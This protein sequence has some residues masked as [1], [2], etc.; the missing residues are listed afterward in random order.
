MNERYRSIYQL[1]RLNAG[2]TQ[3]VAAQLIGVAPRTLAGYEA[4][5]PIPH[6]DVVESMVDVY[7]AEWLA[8]EH[9]RISTSVGR[10]FLPKIDFTDIAKSVLVLQK[11]SNDVEQIKNTMVQIACDGNIDKHERERWLEVSK[12]VMEL[13]GA[14]LSVVFS[15]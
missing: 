15:R 14:A 4:E 10:R 3:D 11:E 6:G 13:A 12:E 5:S 9:L 1:A 7:G 2:M 8:Y